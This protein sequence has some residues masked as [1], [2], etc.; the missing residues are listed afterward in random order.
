MN[1]HIYY[2]SPNIKCKRKIFSLV[3]PHSRKSVEFFETPKCVLDD[4]TEA[5]DIAVPDAN[6]RREK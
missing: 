3:A 2:V 5:A 6:A 1:F 4:D